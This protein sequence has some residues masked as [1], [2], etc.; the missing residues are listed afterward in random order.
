MISVTASEDKR[1]ASRQVA[2]EL[3]A[4]IES[5]DYSP[6][7]SL[8]TYRQLA[9]EFDVA[10][11]TALAAIRLLR[12]EGL[13]TIRK[14]AGARVRDRSSDVDVAAELRVLRDQVSALRADFSKAGDQLSELEGRLSTLVDEVAADEP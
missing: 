7:S 4:R 1:P 3:A 10:V 8:P 13:V 5:G 12:D 6:G 14:N 2:D 9:A 11:N